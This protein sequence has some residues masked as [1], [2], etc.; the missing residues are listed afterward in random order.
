MPVDITVLIGF[1]DALS[2][3][4]VA[5]SLSDA[6]FRVVAFG[7]RG[8]RP[9]LR[10]SRFVEMSYISDPALS[11]S[12]TLSD[13]AR[14]I[15]EHENP[16][17]MPLDDDSLWLVHHLPRELEARSGGATGSQLAVAL[18]K[19]LQLKAAGRAG[20]AVPE[21][22][23]VQ[24]AEDLH[25][26][27]VFPC[28]LKPALAARIVADSLGRGRAFPCADRAELVALTS[29]WSGR[30]PMLAQPLLSGVGEGLFGLA[31]DNR[32]VA[33]SGHRRVRMMNPG[34]SGSSAC[35][36]MEPGLEV[37]AAA[38]H[39]LKALEWRGL[40]MIELLR[41][42]QERL[43]FM[44]LNGRPWG[45]MALARRRGFEYPAWAVKRLLNPGYLPQEPHAGPPLLCRHLGREIL[46][47]AFVVRGP[48]SRALRTW[49][50]L[51]KTLRDLL[52]VWPH[53]AFY[54][55]RKDDALVF[56]SDT[57]ET[58]RTQFRARPARGTLRRGLWTRAL[59]RPRSVL[60][61]RKQ[62]RARSDGTVV[63][64]VAGVEKRILFLCYGNI[65]RSALAER[66]L[67]HLLDGDA[68]ISSC[69]FH[70]QDRRAAD[71]LMAALVKEHGFSLEG[72]SSRAISREMVAQADVILAM[73]AKHLVRLYRDY[74]DAKG[75]A[76]LLSCV[77]PP[78]TMA[79]EI[80]D[81]F[82]RS[83]SD[84]EQC[85][86]EITQ[87]TSTLAVLMRPS[88]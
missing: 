33:W 70:A 75:R 60:E 6:G 45:S 52:T 59:D 54:N 27:E 5:W 17:L 63:R 26:L 88:G 58:V 1:A 79:L 86:K 40:F 55:W 71:P 3:P 80:R 47:L 16:I 85:W 4:E 12:R 62:E 46:H 28:I 39:F 20:F 7:R 77:T 51:L 69:G 57:Y 78:G 15:R 35:I 84:Y 25:R 8:T 21:T 53:Q 9:A 31:L 68:T 49:P 61:R 32:V 82:G 29:K 64:A 48:K 66:Y 30:E 2:A 38:E 43:W 18:D 83:R 81:P 67:K 44:E 72:W 24:Y 65:N 23:E 50:S 76:F 22:I 19:R 36:S 73:E 11:A 34:G 37:R 87:A 10:H 74:P 14:V 41:D 13:L 56:F 42:A